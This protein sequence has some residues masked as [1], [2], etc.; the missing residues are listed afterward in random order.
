MPQAYP[1]GA[2]AQGSSARRPAPVFH[3]PPQPPA[4]PRTAPPRFSLPATGR[5]LRAPWPRG[6]NPCPAVEALPSVWPS[7]VPGVVPQGAS[8]G[9]GSAAGG[10]V[11]SSGEGGT[12]RATGSAVPGATPWTLGLRQGAGVVCGF[13]LLAPVGPTER[14]ALVG[15][16]PGPGAKRPRDDALGTRWGGASQ[17][18]HPALI[19]VA[20]TRPPC[21]PRPASP[22]L[23]RGRPGTRVRVRALGSVPPRTGPIGAGG[24]DPIGESPPASG[25]GPSIRRVRWGG[26]SPGMTV[27]VQGTASRASVAPARSGA[28]TAE[29]VAGSRCRQGGTDEWLR[30]SWTRRPRRR[31]TA[32]R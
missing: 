12:D 4:S 7:R 18:L 19:T 8:R 27:V 17:W 26:T 23:R 11:G 28:A 6:R 32:A 31:W 24:A 20:D 30:A 15:A 22:R 5:L 1:T 16:G 9:R 29:S 2:A 25:V 13:R 21:P 14:V 3:G 10:R